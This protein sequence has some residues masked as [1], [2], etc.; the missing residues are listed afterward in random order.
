VPTLLIHPVGRLPHPTTM[1]P[2]EFG[3]QFAHP[4]RSGPAE[5]PLTV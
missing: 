1:R 3:G 2:D 5:R 4:A